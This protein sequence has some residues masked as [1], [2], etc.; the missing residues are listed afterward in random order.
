[1]V[2]RSLGWVQNPSNFGKLRKVVEIFNEQTQ[3]HQ[4]IK[5]RTIPQ[6]VE[7]RDGR[8]RLIE[9]LRARPLEITYENLV[10]K[11]FQKRKE[12]RCN[13]IVQ[14]AVPSQGEKRFTDDWTADGFVRWAHA[15]G[16]ISYNR[17]NDTFKITQLG[18]SYTNA[19]KDSEQEGAILEQALLSYPPAVRILE[20]LSD[21]EIHTKFELGKKLGF[22]GEAGFTSLPQD[23]FIIS[24][25]NI[26]EAKKRNELRTNW[27]GSA[28]KY[29]RM[30]STWLHKRGWVS[31]ESKEVTATSGGQHYTNT[32]NQAYK[33]TA[34]GISALRKSRGGSRHAR[35]AK[36][37][38]WEML[39]PGTTKYYC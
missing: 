12:A 36:N 38:F 4:D 33:I 10:G 1:L 18:L 11:G 3:T 7:E 14:A 32:I 25:A 17:D 19:P 8:D 21:N 30:I 5:D 29:A 6:L 27:E 13:G 15:L 24:L 28:D 22:V 20:L 26:D 16:F 2:Y 31:K 9:Q 23:Q 39:F 35:I 34:E 37:V